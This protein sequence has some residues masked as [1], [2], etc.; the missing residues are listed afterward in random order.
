MHG[1]G[2]VIVYS[3]SCVDGELRAVQGQD[4]GRLYYGT[5]SGI[6]SYHDIV[7]ASYSVLKQ[8]TKLGRI[9]F[10]PEYN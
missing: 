8:G 2:E 10:I 6:I 5:I 7:V 9:L 1:E 4:T 3:S